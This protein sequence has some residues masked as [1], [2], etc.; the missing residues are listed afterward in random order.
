MRPS[1]S[2]ISELD[3]LRRKLKFVQDWHNL[4]ILDFCFLVRRYLQMCWPYYDFKTHGMTLA[5]FLN[6][7]AVI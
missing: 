2:S 1:K 5:C 4:L 6:I 7:L 3:R